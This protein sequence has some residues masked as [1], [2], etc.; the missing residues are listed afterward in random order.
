MTLLRDKFA[1]PY[2]GVAGAHLMLEA[3]EKRRERE[4]KG[5]P[6]TTVAAAEFPDSLVDEVCDNLRR[7]FWLW[8]QADD[9]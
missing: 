9:R 8:R 7:S 5:K 4:A 1:D 2:I 6:L 3:I